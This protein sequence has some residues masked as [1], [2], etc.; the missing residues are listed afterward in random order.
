MNIDFKTDLIVFSLDTFNAHKLRTSKVVSNLAHKRR[1]FYIETPV[2]GVSAYPTYF[3][4]KN[5]DDIMVVKP[6]LPANLSV[7]EQKTMLQGIIRELMED[8]HITSYSIWSDTPRAMPFIRDLAPELLIYDCLV[9]HSQTHPVLEREMFKK[10]HVVITSGL[11][12]KNHLGFHPGFFGER[13]SPSTE[14]SWN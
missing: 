3:L 4:Q 8:E 14:L 9:D 11:S 10:A 2:I 6:Y 12:E 13:K 5:H 1:V 7:F